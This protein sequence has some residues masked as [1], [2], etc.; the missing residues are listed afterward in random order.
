MY[1]EY[2]KSVLLSHEW[3]SE[4][5]PMERGQIKGTNYISHII[6]TAGMIYIAPIVG[7][8]SILFTFCIMQEDLFGLERA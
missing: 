6:L 8:H 3:L 1:T 2:G 5:V 7:F 4:F